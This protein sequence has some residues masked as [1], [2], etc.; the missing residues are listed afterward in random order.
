MTQALIDHLYDAVDWLDVLTRADAA[1]LA[2][3]II[4]N[5]IDE[6]REEL[7][8]NPT[9]PKRTFLEWQLLLANLRNLVEEQVAEL[10]ENRV[11]L[12]EVIETIVDDAALSNAPVKS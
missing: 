4:D 3:S 1:V 2:S 12:R 5:L 7:Q 11:D 6:L 8:N 10:I 9:I